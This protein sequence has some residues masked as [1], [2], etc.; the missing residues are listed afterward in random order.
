[1]TNTNLCAGIYRFSNKTRHSWEVSGC[2]KKHVCDGEE[3]SMRDGV[4]NI[5]FFFFMTQYHSREWERN[6]KY[7]LRSINKIFYSVFQLIRKSLFI[8]NPLLQISVCAEDFFPHEIIARGKNI[9]VFRQKSV[10]ENF[11]FKNFR[12]PS[13]RQ[14]SKD[15]THTDI[16]GFFIFSY[17]KV[18]SEEKKVERRS[19]QQRSSRHLWNRVQTAK[20]RVSL[21]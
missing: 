20:V 4:L 18:E 2:T 1:M 5:V 9:P 15:V 12:Q 14:Y 6:G 10:S 8:S 13:R 3:K 11:P 16:V 7:T 17:L 19:C 21:I